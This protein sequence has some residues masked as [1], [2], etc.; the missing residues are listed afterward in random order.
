M[1]ILFRKKNKHDEI[2]IHD[3]FVSKIL[4]LYQI[5]I[6]TKKKLKLLDKILKYNLYYFKK[7]ILQYNN[8]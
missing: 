8:Y 4:I 6:F 7:N 2:W 3:C 5:I 1:L